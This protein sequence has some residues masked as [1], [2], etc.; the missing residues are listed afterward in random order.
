ME[1][2]VTTSLADQDEEVRLAALDQ[3]VA[4]D[5]RP[6]VARYVQALKQS[7]NAIINRAAAG[8]GLMKDP[9][10]VGPLIDALVTTHTFRMQQGQPG[11][12]TTTFGTW[13]NSGGFNFGGSGVKTVKRQFQNRD[14]LQALVDLTDGVSYNYDVRAWK[15]WYAAQKKPKTLDARRDSS[16]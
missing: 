8:L 7:D 13:P 9:G 1:V 16:Q 14:V 5:Y 10:A 12:T 3:V 4:N 11:Q 2:L 15:N 6:A